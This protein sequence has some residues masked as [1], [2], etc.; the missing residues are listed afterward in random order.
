M[1]MPHTSKQL[2]KLYLESFWVSVYTFS[3]G[4]FGAHSGS[5]KTSSPRHQLGS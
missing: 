5:V 1:N 4:V 3:F 2:L